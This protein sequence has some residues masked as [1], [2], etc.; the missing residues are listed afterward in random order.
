MKKFNRYQDIVISYNAQR[1]SWYPNLGAFGHV[2]PRPMFA[3]KAEATDVAK[4]VFERWQNR[5]ETGVEEPVKSDITLEE[6]LDMF[7]ANSKARA[8]NEDEKYGWASYSNGTGAVN[9]IKQVVWSIT[10]H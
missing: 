9:I 3:T 6:C 1:E 10:S 7:L 5:D 4:A 8:E 2:P